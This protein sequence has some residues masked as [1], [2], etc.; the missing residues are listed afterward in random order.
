MNEESKK[1]HEEYEELFGK[2]KRVNLF[3]T[4]EE[5]EALHQ[6]ILTQSYIDNS[7]LCELFSDHQNI[8]TCRIR[9][10]DKNLTTLE[11]VYPQI[12]SPESRENVLMSIITS[13]EQNARKLE[14]AKSILSLLKSMRLSISSELVVLLKLWAIMSLQT[15]AS[16]F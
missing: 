1:I 15:V 9:W 3:D 7:H 4:D 2:A 8:E 14:N 16:L 11:H 5:N 6:Y 10:K 13:L 12:N